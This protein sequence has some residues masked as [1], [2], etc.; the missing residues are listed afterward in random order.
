MLTI[1][2]TG[3]L[4]NQMAGFYRSSYTNIHGQSK[5][6]A[7]TQFE[8][9]DARRAFP[10]WD[11]P[12]R[13]AIFGL[14]LIVPAHLDCLSN[15]PTKSCQS[16]GGANNK[17]LVQ[18]LDSPKMS[19]Y[20]LAFC[21]GEFDHV[22]AQTSHGVMVTVYTPPGK[23]SSGQFAL[24]CATESLDAFNDFFGV[25]FPLP[26]LDMIAIPE[27]AAGAMVSVSFFI[28]YFIVISNYSL[29]SILPSQ[30]CC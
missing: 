14:T 1:H 9:L 16:L 17:K 22:Q 8:A 21:V 30:V 2:Y 23:S 18:F 3:F 11:E 29:I 6:M 26:K 12:A 24:E 19:T 20:L 7:S 15:M 13:K 5:I 27:F 4:N 25:P 28:I 10:C